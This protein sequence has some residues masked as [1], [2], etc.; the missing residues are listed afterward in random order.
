MSEEIKKEE[1]IIFNGKEITQEE[2]VVEKKK[3]QEKKGVELVE[4]T[5]TEFKTRLLD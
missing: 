3:L 1:K 4:I 2:F 5:T